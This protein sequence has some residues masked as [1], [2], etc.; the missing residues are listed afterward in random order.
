MYHT[1]GVFDED[2]SNAMMIFHQ[3]MTMVIRLRIGGTSVSC[4]PYVYL[5]IGCRLQKK[6]MTRAVK[7]GKMRLV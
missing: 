5:I 7:D 4:S 2:I 3:K 1:G 6:I